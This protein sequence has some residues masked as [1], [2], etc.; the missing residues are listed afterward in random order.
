M[1]IQMTQAGGVADAFIRAAC[2]PRQG[3]HMDGTLNEARMLLA[4]NPALPQHNIHV[5][6]ILGDAPTLRNFLTADRE[7]ATRKG[8]PYGWDPL[9]HLCFSRFLRVERERSAQFVACA[10]LLLDAGAS[11]NSGFFET[12]H[13][14]TPEWESVL[15]GA[16]G[17]A[18]DGA[19]AR[20]L[21]K[22]GADVNA[23]EVTYH[24]PESYDNDA[25]LA[26]LESGRLIE[27]SLATMLLRKVD[28]H[29][30]DG[31]R[32][33]LEQ[34]AD[35]N[36]LTVW[37]RNALHNAISRDNTEAIVALMLD[38][39]G[40]PTVRSERQPSYEPHA[41]GRDA[42]A[43]AAW[44][45]RGD[46]LDLFASRGV[47]VKLGGLDALIAACARDDATAIATLTAEHPGI[48]SELRG[49]GAE[50][51]TLFALTG[52]ASGVGHL[53]DRGV[54]PNARIARSN[55]YWNLA[56]GSTALH[57]AAW[58]SRPDVVR[59]LLARGA[60]PDARDAEGRTPLALAVKACVDSYWTE[61]ATPDSVHA[62]LQ[63]GA[64]ADA[65]GI[66][67]PSGFEPVDALLRTHKLSSSTSSDS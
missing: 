49:A 54:D 1:P 56:A 61:R 19:L 17:I 27:D 43:M 51:L 24:T 52:N 45:G 20:L 66:D 50:A 40:D 8:G 60:D 32:L 18:H 65:P 28:W 55:G 38:H 34:G 29:D 59:V 47:D 33:L 39:G 2:V 13:L 7:A 46:L 12:E 22:H 53:L 36:R 10:Q 9:T 64:R 57:A 48:A 11:A 3:S 25:M 6:A 4:T 42:I 41:D 44:H 67:Y 26:L 31:V 5:A 16:A 30:V 37:R 35:P 62:L 14:P 23:G 58:L 21:V 15:Y 63:A